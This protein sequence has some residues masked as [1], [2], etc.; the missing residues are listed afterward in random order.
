MA[1]TLEQYWIDDVARLT[2]RLAAQQSDIDTERA[3]LL[4]AQATRLVASDAVKTQNTAV[5]AARKALGA[6]AM[7]A[8]GDPLLVALEAALVGLADAQAGLAA[9]DLAAQ[10]AAA[11]LARLQTDATALAMALADAQRVATLEGAARA[12]RQAM[13]DRLSSGDLATLAADAAAALAAS[14]ATARS[15]VEGEFPANADDAKDFVKRVRARRAV[16]AASLQSAIE[17]EGAAFDADTPALAQAQRDF[18]AAVAGLRL[19]ANAAPSLTADSTTLARQAALPAPNPPDSYP[20]VTRWQHDR[21]HDG[22]KQAAREG[23]LAKLTDADNAVSAARAAQQ[24]YDLAV[25]AAMKAEPDKTAAEL[26]AT[27]VAAERAALTSSLGDLDTARVALSAGDLAAVQSWFATVPDTLWDELDKLDV[28][29]A[30]L[31]AL[32]GPPTPA[33]RIDAVTAAETALTAALDADRLAQREHAAAESALRRAAAA[34]QAERETADAR[35]RA[36]AHS[37]ALF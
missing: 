4:A 30:R 8:D 29:L 21:L 28:A 3:T 35:A 24:A 15:R 9:S 25:N 31:A 34:L 18:E 20:I 22:G 36:F 17:V 11:E 37:A 2:T 33:D 1:T 16:V 14:E 26:D 27:T 12:D 7:P 6:V 23:A 32:A 13:I 10:L 19:V 5:D